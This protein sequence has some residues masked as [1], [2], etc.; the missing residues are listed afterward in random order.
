MSDA[1]NRRDDKSTDSELTSSAADMIPPD[2]S[3]RLS[4]KGMERVGS[5]LRRLRKENWITLE[6]AAKAVGMPKNRLNKIERGTYVQ[7]DL[8]HLK[9][10]CKVYGVTVEAFLVTYIDIW[11]DEYSKSKK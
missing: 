9:R 11:L 8:T 6:T 3:W 4:R 2:L 7:F 10:L 1:K 5:K